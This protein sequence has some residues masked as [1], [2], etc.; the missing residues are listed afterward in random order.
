MRT[1]FQAYLWKKIYSYVYNYNAVVV[2][3]RYSLW[4]FV[5][6]TKNLV[7][8]CLYFRD[9]YLL[10]FIRLSLLTVYGWMHDSKEA[11]MTILWRDEAFQCTQPINLQPNQLICRTFIVW[12][13][14]RDFSIFSV[15][16]CW[17]F[18]LLFFCLN[19]I[20]F[21]NYL[22]FVNYII[23]CLN[24][25]SADRRPG[26]VARDSHVCCGLQLQLAAVFHA[27]CHC[28][29]MHQA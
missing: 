22:I 17:L 7:F 2:L 21:V 16:I 18:D 25:I 8:Y 6:L 27:S 19:Y 28:Q 23:F 3:T 24:Y 5:I 4:C 13:F 29:D 9:V 20:I 11:R 14:I 10:E 15:L 26:W 1:W 12:D